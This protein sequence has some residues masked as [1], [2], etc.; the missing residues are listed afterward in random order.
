[1]IKSGIY[2]IQSIIKPNK[3]YI[4]SAINI[5]A[6]WRKHLCELKKGKHGSIIL[7]NH[8]NKYGIKDFEFYILEECS[9]ETLLI[10]EQFYMDMYNP[11][12]NIRKIAK[13]NF[14]MKFSEEHKRKI[15]EAGKGRKHT[16]EAKKKMS[17]TRIKNGSFK[18]SEEAKKKMSV[19]K[20]GRPLSEEHKYNISL[21]TKGISKPRSVEHQQ[22]LNE[23]YKGRVSWNKGILRD[24]ETKRKISETKLSQ[25]IHF[26][27]ERKEQIRIRMLNMSDETRKKISDKKRERDKLEKLR[28]LETNEK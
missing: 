9:K 27:D 23:S 26:S 14:G 20:K 10:R 16:E 18:I 1:M 24:S 6:R 22:R 4:G 12:F 11:Y 2:K 7:Q 17:I 15:G 25:N 3:L 28:K 13:S 21:A 5:G 8:C 19:A